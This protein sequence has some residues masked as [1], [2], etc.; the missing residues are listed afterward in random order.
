[1]AVRPGAEGAGRLKQEGAR[2]RTWAGS[3]SLEEGLED[4]DIRD[5]VGRPTPAAPFISSPRNSWQGWDTDDGDAASP[6]LR[7]HF[8]GT[9]QPRLQ[10]AVRTSRSC[11]DPKRASPMAWIGG[12]TITGSL[13]PVHMRIIPVPPAQEGIILAI[14]DWSGSPAAGRQIFCLSCLCQPLFPNR[15]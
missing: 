4:W 12:V 5:K 6:G 8:R 14:Q 13:V 3:S 2:D 15:G 7:R 11:W 10:A 1:M 9:A